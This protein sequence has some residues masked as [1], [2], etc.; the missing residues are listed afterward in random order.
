MVTKGQIEAKI[1]EAIIK[2]EKEYMGRGPIETKTYV[3]ED[4]IL[5]RLQGVITRAE[6]HL[7][8]SGDAGKGRELIKQTRME[9]IEKARPLL[10]SVIESIVG[11][12]VLSLHTD[13]STRTGERVIIFTLEREPCLD[14]AIKSNS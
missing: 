9:L 7:A 2:F 1:S 4:M 10:E 13:I 5:V 14:Q 6:H 3:I 12:P 8:T 11:Q